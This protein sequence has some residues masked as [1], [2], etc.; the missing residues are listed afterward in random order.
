MRPTDTCTSPFRFRTSVQS[1]FV[2]AD[3]LLHEFDVFRNSDVRTSCFAMRRSRTAI[4]FRTFVTSEEL[5][6]SS[7]RSTLVQAQFFSKRRKLQFFFWR[8][9][10]IGARSSL[11]IFIIRT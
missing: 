8:K 7:S 4:A 2:I 6:F 3:E 10:L 9:I 1:T 11:L 5:I